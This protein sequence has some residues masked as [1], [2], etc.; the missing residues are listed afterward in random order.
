[1]VADMNLRLG[2]DTLT[3]H[4]A[5][6]SGEVDLRSVIEELADLDFDFVQLNAHHLR[7]DTERTVEQVRRSADELLLGLTLAGSSVGRAREGDSVE[8]GARRVGEWLNLAEEL[9]SPFVRVSSGFYRNELWRDAPAIAAERSYVIRVLQQVIQANPGNTMVIL[10]NH[11]DFTPEEYIEIF[12]EVGSDRVGGFLDLI[13]PVS[14]LLDPLPVVQ[15]LAPWA[16]AGHVKDYRL[17]SNYIEDGFFRRGFE[18][19]WC[20]P[21]EGVADLQGLLQVLRLVRPDTPYYL[22]I[23]GLDN[24]A[25]VADQRQRLSNSRKLLCELLG[26]AVQ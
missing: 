8:D 23:E 15:R 20:Y 1:M 3:Y 21:G 22:S 17:Q 7:H 14:L 25:G 10:E 24:R 12:E 4:C 2:V 9:G 16:V 13:N 26:N 5:L 6:E 11:S 18:V 19:Q